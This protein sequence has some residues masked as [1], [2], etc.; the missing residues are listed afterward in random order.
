MSLSYILMSPSGE[1][2]LEEGLS[3]ELTGLSR[4][5]TASTCK[6]EK[7]VLSALAL[8]GDP[9]LEGAFQGNVSEC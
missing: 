1:G 9:G 8:Q 3:R 7:Y 5:L 4:K 2:S 6:S